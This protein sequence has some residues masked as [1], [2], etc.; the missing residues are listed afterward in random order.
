MTDIRDEEPEVFEGLGTAG[1]LCA[2]FVR[3]STSSIS[4]HSWGMAIDINLNGRLDSPGN[5]KTQSGLAR[6]APVFNRHKWYWGAGFPREDAMHFELSDQKTRE[7]HS[8]G[9][10]GAI[11]HPLPDPAL[12]L[13]DRG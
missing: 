4:N 11:P 13:G 6:I 1:M 8:A 9:A 2:R 3:G 5:G 12:S 7:L 10:F